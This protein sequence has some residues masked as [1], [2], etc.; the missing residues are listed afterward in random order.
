MRILELP[1]DAP[2]VERGRIH[3]E[4][5]R[6]EI[7]ALVDLRMHLCR[8][9]GGFPDDAA[10]L[11]V[12][13][14][15]LPVLEG[16]HGD[17]NAELMGIAEGSGRSPAEIVVLNHYT[18]LRDLGPAAAGDDGGCTAVFARTPGG[19][20]LGQTWDMHASAMPFVMML[21]IPSAGDQPGAWL[22]S[23]VGCLGMTGM[24][25]AGVGV[26]IN[27]LRSSDATVGIV[28]PALVRGALLEG[29]AEAAKDHVVGAPVGS[30]HHYLAADGDRAFGIETSGQ[31]RKVVYEGTMDPYVHTNHCL[32]SEV[33]AVTTIAPVSSTKERYDAIAESLAGRPLAG[34]QDLWSRLG[35]TEGWPKSVCGY[36]PTP[37]EP[38]RSATCGAVVMDLGKCEA[39]AGAGLTHHVRPDV[40]HLGSEAT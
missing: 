21:R 17:L 6:H 32:D 9:V 22:F 1:D 33:A 36:L 29:T 4:A 34:A 8:T 24:N 35:S 26:T 12:A 19:P 37:T 10:V 25:D 18:D 5:F 3:G 40:F 28:W 27:N 14:K 16:Y 7:G 11:A 15:H 13:E 23:L 39:L 30:G 2:P 20:I 31:L 38:H